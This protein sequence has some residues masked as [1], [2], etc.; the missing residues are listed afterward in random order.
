MKTFRQSLGI[1]I[2]L[3]LLFFIIKPFVQTQEDLKHAAFQIHWQWLIP[4]FGVLLFY[5]SFYIYPFAALLRG[6][7]RK[8]VPSREAFIL[9]HL[10]NITRYLP[11]RIWGVVRLLSLSGQFG[12][13][14][15]SGG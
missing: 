2:A 12:L 8:D 1:L 10:S 13:R 11:G 14:R 15:H 4:S 6:L 9:F 7:S 5:R 3:I